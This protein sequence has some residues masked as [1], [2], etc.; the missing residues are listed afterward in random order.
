MSLFRLMFKKK[1]TM[2]N[3]FEWICFISVLSA[4][5][6]DTDLQFNIFKSKVIQKGQTVCDRN[7][8][9]SSLDLFINSGSNLNK[10]E[11][12]NLGKV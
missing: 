11:P 3:L 6:Y 8:L 1:A 10:I 7:K 12:E 4:S 9:S 5:E 2:D